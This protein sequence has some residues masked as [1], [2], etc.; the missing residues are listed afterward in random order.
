MAGALGGIF[1]AQFAGWVLDATGSYWPLFAGS[2]FAYVTAW[3]LIQ[4]LLPKQ[5]RSA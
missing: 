1:V 2:A 5:R 3:L 4:I